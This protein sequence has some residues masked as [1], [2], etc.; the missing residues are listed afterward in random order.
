MQ[1]Y[2]ASVRHFTYLVLVLTF[3][4]PSLR[5]DQHEFSSDTIFNVKL[6]YKFPTLSIN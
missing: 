5:A 1:Q 2:P 4:L 6:Q 3:C